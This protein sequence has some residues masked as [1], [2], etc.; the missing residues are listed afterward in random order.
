MNAQLSTEAQRIIAS[1][2][3][4]I[5]RGAAKWDGSARAGQQLNGDPW[6]LAINAE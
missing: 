3:Q 5:R 1:D 4:V 2:T 6:C